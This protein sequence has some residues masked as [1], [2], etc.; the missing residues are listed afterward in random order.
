MQLPSNKVGAL[1]LAVV[2]M[3]VLIIGGDVFYKKIAP[4]KTLEIIDA[5]LTIQRNTSNESSVDS[6]EDGLLDW[7]ESLY[8]SNPN[9]FD[10]D[11][12]GT[13]DGDEIKDGRD[14]TIAGP[15]DQLIKIND[16]INSDFEAEGYEP[17]TLTDTF[18]KELFANYF[19]L[20]S[21]DNVNS[22]TGQEL[23]N[24]LTTEVSSIDVL[25][26]PYSQGDL[27]LV[28]T[29]KNSLTKYG[30]EVAIV[31]SDYLKQ[32]DSFSNLEE[33]VYVNKISFL[34]KQLAEVLSDVL[35]PDVA[36]TIHL[37]ILN[38]IYAKAVLYETLNEYEK[39]PIKSLLVIKDFRESNDDEVVLFE[40]LANYFR[41]NDIIFTDNEI[42][43]F[44]NL[45]E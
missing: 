7:Q 6:D 31:Y 43:R 23:I 21:N 1:F 4:E 32:M 3:V 20:K 9:S 29:N 14:P 18:S 45:F 40:K 2:L 27:L 44:W 38:S 22:Q 24:K 10:T 19:D 39:D 41:D 26:K 16:L 36:M 33:G 35:V 34:Y 11:G 13:G 37:D 5:D 28:S 17:G 8:G 42:I 30:K 12:D 25:E 15:E